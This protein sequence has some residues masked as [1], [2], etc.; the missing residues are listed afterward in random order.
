MNDQQ[1]H[2]GANE[3]AS[4]DCPEQD[5]Q[6]VKPRSRGIYLLP[7]LFTTGALF[8]GFYAVVA[9]MNGQFDSAAIAI[10]VAMVLDGLMVG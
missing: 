3:S 1:D 4:K 9:G 7:N 10:F 8:C 5:Q 2:N 6:S